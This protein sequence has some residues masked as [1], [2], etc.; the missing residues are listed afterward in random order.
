[1]FKKYLFITLT[2]ILMVGNA[3]AKSWTFKSLEAEQAEKN[4]VNN[5]NPNI[6]GVYQLD[7]IK[8]TKSNLQLKND[9][10]FSWFVTYDKTNLETSGEWRMSDNEPNIIILQSNPLPE[11][12]Q[13]DYKGSNEIK[14]KDNYKMIMSGDLM[15]NISYDSKLGIVPGGPLKGIVVECEGVMKKKTVISDDN[16]QAYC[17]G[18]GMPLKKLT[19]YS[20]N[21]PNRTVYE[22]PKFPGRSWNIDFDYIHASSDYAFMNERMKIDDNG[23]LNWIPSSIG[24]NTEWTYYR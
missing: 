4:I 17:K 14:K 8:E 22:E 2:G 18:V 6:V 19:M 7:G 16:G 10:T 9:G 20:P 1:M 13:F 11:D 3:N 24:G 5:S 15:L 21:L 12:I 23:N